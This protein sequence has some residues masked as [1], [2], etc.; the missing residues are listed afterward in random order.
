MSC[1]STCE[2]ERDEQSTCYNYRSPQEAGPVD[3]GSIDCIELSYMRSLNPRT[4]KSSDATR[5]YELPARADYDIPSKSMAYPAIPAFSCCGL[6]TIAHRWRSRRQS[7]AD[8]RKHPNEIYTEHQQ[9][10]RIEEQ[11]R[12]EQRAQQPPAYDDV[13]S[14]SGESVTGMGM[15]R[16]PVMVQ[17]STHSEQSSQSVS[18]G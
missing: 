8:L 15:Q 14:S 6:L 17:H 12:A 16:R 11:R 7:A 9:M 13:L 18:S 2:Q 10:R 5:Y 4:S 3:N 1:N